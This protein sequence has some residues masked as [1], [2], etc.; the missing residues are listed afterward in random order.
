MDDNKIKDISPINSLT[1][2]V[3]ISLTDNQIENIPPLNSLTKLTQLSLSNNM[4][5]DILPLN[6]L[7]N[8]RHLSLT[9]NMIEDIS[10]LNS[11]TNLQYLYLN[12][13]MIKDISP[14]SSLTKITKLLVRDNIISTELKFG[15][16]EQIDLPPII[17][18]AKQI[19]SKIYTENGYT[20]DNC[21]LSEDGE[22][23]IVD[24]TKTAKASVQ[25]SGGNADGTQFLLNVE[26]VITSIQVTTKP[27]KTQYIQNYEEIDLTGGV[28]TITYNDNTTDTIS[29][30]NENVKVTG[31]NNSNIGDNVLTVEYEGKQT[32][33][34]V[35]IVSK[36]ITEIKVTKMPTKT[37]YIQNYEKIDLT[38][39]IITVTYNDNT[40]DTISMT[41]ENIEVTGFNNRKIGKNVLTIDYK[42]KETT[43]EVEIVAKQ[44]TG[45]QVTKMPTKTSYIQNY[46]IIDLTGGVITVT[47]NDDST[48][49]ISMTNENVEVTGFSNENVGKNVLTVKYEGKQATFEIEIILKQITGIQVTKMP[50]KMSYIQNDEKMDLTGGVIT[51][52][53]NDNTTDTISM[54]NENIKVTGFNNKNIGKN[55]LTIEYMG[56]QTMFEVDIINITENEE[57][58]NTATSNSGTNG[59]NAETTKSNIAVLPKAGAGGLIIIIS[60]VAII[61]IILYKK[62]EKYKDIK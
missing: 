28:I 44:I 36:Q 16:T 25:I 6:S 50:T 9:N 51:V 53:Y 27:T 59:K 38:G 8:L 2:L 24:T 54:T 21:S 61:T 39:G 60:A 18:Q 22:K 12:G 35:E 14:I 32:T 29:M 26:K 11:L 13:N 42:G 40:T 57:G 20:L 58:G 3:Y 55:T 33:F 48:D 23:V 41:N 4:I 10:P 46:E 15:K 17:K 19:N 62:N 31:F 7:T 45:I 49:T 52:T 1:N 47:Y 43:F 34:D 56:H 30:T 5:E 37:S